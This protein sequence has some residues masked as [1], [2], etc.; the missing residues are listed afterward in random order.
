MTRI[1]V[2]LGSTRPQRVGHQV[3]TWV[4]EIAARR[5]DATY[6]LIDLRDHP[7][8]LFDEP[9]TPFLGQYQHDH[10]RAWA[11]LIATYDGFVFVTPE[12]N[13]FT[14]AALK[15]AIDY[16]HAEWRNKAVGLVS[17]GLSG[18]LGAAGQLRQMCG[19]L[20]MADVPQQVLL[21]M[22][23]DFENYTV[24]TPSD[25]HAHSLGTL[26]DQVI[27]WSAALAPLRE[28]S[29]ATFGT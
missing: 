21:S 7:L 15:N 20:G 27:G 12:Y 14:S 1:A 2:I 4:H 13:R 10:T 11:R 22:L 28:Q 3:A 16:L 29:L 19:Q 17:Y 26:L 9:L 24:F 6:E 8:P 25:H 23:T 5:T 18:G